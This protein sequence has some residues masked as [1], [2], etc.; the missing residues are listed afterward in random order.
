MPD[1]YENMLIGYD[2]DAA[3]PYSACLAGTPPGPQTPIGLGYTPQQAVQCLYRLLAWQSLWREGRSD[4]VD[5]SAW[6]DVA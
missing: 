2:P 4:E 3:I 6:P 1:T 5:D